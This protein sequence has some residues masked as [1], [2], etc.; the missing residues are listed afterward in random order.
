MN[1]EWIVLLFLGFS[2][3]ST[4]VNKFREYQNRQDRPQG[5]LSRSTT[6]YEPEEEEIDLSEWEVF[7]APP[8]PQDEGEFQEVRGRRTVSEDYSGEEFRE[9]TG[10][11]TVNE[12]STREEFQEVRGKRQVRED[13]PA[14]EFRRPEVSIVS[15]P[16][17]ES[18]VPGYGKKRKRIKLNLS[19]KALRN[20]MI[21]NEVMGPPRSE[22]MPW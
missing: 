21:F 14:V 8:E 1:V 2:V 11:R 15:G 16:G 19:R 3:V 12:T 20:A 17:V 7:Q 18:V 22:T 10:Q 9:V 13:L 5:P 4:L 6:V